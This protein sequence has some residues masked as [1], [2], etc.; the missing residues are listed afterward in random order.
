MRKIT[1]IF[2]GLFLL[3][4]CSQ[5][6]NSEKPQTQLTAR[7][8]ENQSL[9]SEIRSDSLPQGFYF[10]MSH[11]EYRDRVSELVDENRI[12][13]TEDSTLESMIQSENFELYLNSIYYFNQKKL[14][15]VVNH[16]Y[17]SRSKKTSD[18]EV[19][20]KDDIL[21]LIELPKNGERFENGTQNSKFYWLRGNKRIDY[22]DTLG[23]Y[24]VA[25]S[26]IGEERKIENESNREKVVQSVDE[27]ETIREY[28][29]LNSVD[30]FS[31]NFNHFAIENNLEFRIRNISIKSG[32]YNNVFTYMFNDNIG[33]TGQ[34]NKSSN[35][36]RS[37]TMIGSG[38]GTVNSGL[39]LL[40]VMGGVIAAVNPE[41]SANSR[42]KI[43]KDLGIIGD[44][45]DPSQLSGSVNRN[46][47]KYFISY[48]DLTGLMFGVQNA[49]DE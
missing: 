39:D 1:N 27:E 13:L 20:V 21:S 9:N 37:I 2:L 35:S 44:D 45:I 18:N 38:D 14:F 29:I 26:N 8:L 25:L 17:P 41:L 19:D 33:L 10:G 30:E 42:G 48:N 31:N 12:R 24:I 47:N 5:Q 6:K 49:N 40:L 36:L 3:I 46:G 28:T 23:R 22:Y 11:Q 16:F 7:Q 34:L 4:S 43:M 15:R 32:E